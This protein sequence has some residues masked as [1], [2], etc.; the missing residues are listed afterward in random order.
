MTAEEMFEHLGYEQITY[1]N[2]NQISY[3]CDDNEYFCFDKSKKIINTS[4]YNLTINHL[5]A[6]NKQCQELGWLDD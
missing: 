4:L 5:K 1:E 2:G 3:E 6:I